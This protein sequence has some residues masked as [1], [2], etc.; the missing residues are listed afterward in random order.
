MHK[1]LIFFS[2]MM[3]LI[4]F[5]RIEAA[6]AFSPQGFGYKRGY[7]SQSHSSTENEGSS[8]NPRSSSSKDRTNTSFV[9]KL[10]PRSNNNNSHRSGF[11]GGGN[12]R[13][14]SNG[15]SARKTPFVN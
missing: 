15:A 3:P 2:Y 5:D 14:G 8:S 13:T 11:G 1:S 7:R 12:K 4:L 6:N 10:S 9:L